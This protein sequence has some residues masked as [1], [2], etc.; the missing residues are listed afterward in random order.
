[1]KFGDL[2]NAKRLLDKIEYLEK[3]NIHKKEKF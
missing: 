2:N 3:I 1:M